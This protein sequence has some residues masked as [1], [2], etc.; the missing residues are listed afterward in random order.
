MSESPQKRENGMS[1]RG[2][3]N[4]DL[5]TVPEDHLSVEIDPRAEIC[6]LRVVC[7]KGSQR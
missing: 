4:A 2:T 3:I 7:V 1:R 6:R 5:T